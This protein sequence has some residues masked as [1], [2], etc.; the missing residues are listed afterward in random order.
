V[1]AIA[2]APPSRD[3]PCR[4]LL[5]R[6]RFATVT[7]PHC[8]VTD[9]DLTAPAR[10]SAGTGRTVTGVV[11][12][13]G[14]VRPVSLVVVRGMAGSVLV[15]TSTNGRSYRRVGTAQGSPVAV[16]PPGRTAARYVRVRAVDGLDESM[17][18]EVSVW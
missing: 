13:L 10:L 12:D 15:E 16:H 5:G 11:V 9:G 7:Q 6:N 17:V 14:R 1:R 4:A 18:A 2:G 8:A 3:R